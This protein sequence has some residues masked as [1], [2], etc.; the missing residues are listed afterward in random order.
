MHMYMLCMFMCS[1]CLEDDARLQHAAGDLRELHVEQFRGDAPRG[2]LRIRSLPR[3][4][5]QVLHDVFIGLSL[6][7]TGDARN[8]DRL[9][10]QF[11]AE[12]AV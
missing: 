1:A 4:P 10:R 6:A 8:D 5:A 12:V 2:R 9:A 3:A 11:A 7:G